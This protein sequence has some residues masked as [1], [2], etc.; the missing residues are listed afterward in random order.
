MPTLVRLGK[1]SVRGTASL[2]EYMN[3]V[4]A[5]NVRIAKWVPQLEEENTQFKR[6]DSQTVPT[7]LYTS[8]V[9]QSHD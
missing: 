6:H 1:I 2:E 5:E 8:G 7:K 9:N 4:S 3:R